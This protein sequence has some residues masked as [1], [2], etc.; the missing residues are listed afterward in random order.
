MMP[1]HAVL[2]HS[3]VPVCLA[4]RNDE[5][6]HQQPQSKTPKGGRL[7]M[8]TCDQE[9]AS[10]S[11][12][13]IVPSQEDDMIPLER[14]APNYGTL[15]VL[16]LSTMHLVTSFYATKSIFKQEKRL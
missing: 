5:E 10:Q 16:S 11:T 2:I 4:S 15:V 1:P 9:T 6:V 7:K 13:S 12:N 14:R 3:V 8:E